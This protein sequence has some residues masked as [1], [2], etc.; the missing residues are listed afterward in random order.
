MDWKSMFSSSGHTWHVK[1]Y[2]L[3]FLGKKQE[4]AFWQNV[5]MISHSLLLLKWMLETSI[6]TARGEYLCNRYVG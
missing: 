3:D 2:H 6:F 5:P 1:S 4:K